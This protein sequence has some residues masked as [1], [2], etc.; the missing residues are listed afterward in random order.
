MEIEL[1]EQI[2][3]MEVAIGMKDTFSKLNSPSEC[4]GIES[5]VRNTVNLST[6]DKKA[7]F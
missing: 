4:N 7:A 2:M 1:N 3:L 6:I 5:K